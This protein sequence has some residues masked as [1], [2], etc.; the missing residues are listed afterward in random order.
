LF[1]LVWLCFVLF[2]LVVLCYAGKIEIS[3]LFY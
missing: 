2:G 3:S 1:C